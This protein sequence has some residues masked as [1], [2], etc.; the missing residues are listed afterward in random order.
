[1]FKAYRL[2]L[3]T[4]LFA[5]GL[6]FAGCSSETKT[7]KEPTPAAEKYLEDAREKLDSKHYT[8]ARALV[9][10][11]REEGAPEAEAD[12]LEAD[13]ERAMGEKALA[14][15]DLQE[16]YEHLSAAGR[17]E[18]DDN[19]RFADLIAAIEAG[20]Q[21][22]VMAVELAPLA[23]KAVEVRT[24]SKQAQQLAAQL[25]DDAG[26]SRRALPFYEWLYKVSPGNTAVTMRLATLYAGEGELRSAKR[27]LQKLL[28]KQ[29]ENAVAALKLASVYAELGEHDKAKARYEALVEKH[30]ERTGILLS[31][32]RYLDE[33]GESERAE[34]LR[35]QAREAL[36]GVKRRK[37]RELR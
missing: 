4:A 27:L 36:P 31:Y 33:R 28:L 18:P 30:P 15:G 26:E 19:Q 3:A 25:W 8:E 34:K 11:A 29:P 20:R 2:P 24:R 37:M 1:M 13:L 9:D 6:L 22:G 12:A 23:S 16:A 10:L 21:A 5:I 14:A 32:A 35:E 17:L 7:R